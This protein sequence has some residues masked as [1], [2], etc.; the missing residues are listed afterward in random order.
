MKSP[1]K[2]ERASIPTGRPKVQFPNP[3]T[4]TPSVKERPLAASGADMDEM[5]CIQLA[6]HF[7]CAFSLPASQA[8]MTAFSLAEAHFD[9]KNGP[10]IA[11]LVSRVLDAVR[12][13]RR[14]GFHYNS[15][16]C[17]KC[18]AILTEHER[19]LLDALMMVRRGRLK[20]AEL[21]LMMLCE[22]NDTARAMMWIRELALALP[23]LWHTTHPQRMQ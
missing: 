13:S 12:R 15:P 10:A 23:A 21:E 8:W 3:C 6:R 1:K 19:R 4:R 2:I 20:R 17:E 16:N 22:G 7:F 18:S 11:S 9:Y 5:T 14:S